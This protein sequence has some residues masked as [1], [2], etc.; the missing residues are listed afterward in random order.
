MC[1]MCF[2]WFT[3]DVSREDELQNR[4]GMVENVPTDELEGELVYVDI[5]E[6]ELLY[7]V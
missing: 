4:V 6:D 2:K 7:E 3:E 1:I 5:V